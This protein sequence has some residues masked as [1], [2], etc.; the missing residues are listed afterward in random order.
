MWMQYSSR[1]LTRFPLNKAHKRISEFTR[2][3]KPDSYGLKKKK[4][5]TPNLGPQFRKAPHHKAKEKHII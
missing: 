5:L 3:I 1:L 2:R 4:R